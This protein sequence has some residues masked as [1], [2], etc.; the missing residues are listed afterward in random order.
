MDT[1]GPG[2]CGCL[3]KSSGRRTGEDWGGLGSTAWFRGVILGDAE[4]ALL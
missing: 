3:G 2:E 4:K 1:L